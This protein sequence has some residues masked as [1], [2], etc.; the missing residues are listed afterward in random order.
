MKSRWLIPIAVLIPL[1]L[2]A[3]DTPVGARVAT[4]TIN[5][6]EVSVAAPSR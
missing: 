1:H 2:G 6:R 3:T 4:I 5:P